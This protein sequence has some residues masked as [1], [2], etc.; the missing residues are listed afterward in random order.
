LRSELHVAV[1]EIVN[2]LAGR[3]RS[4][5][6]PSTEYDE[7][8]DIQ[9]GDVFGAWTYRWP[10]G[11]EEEFSSGRWYGV[12]LASGLCQLR[13]AWTTRRAWGRDRERAIV[14]QQVGGSAS[15]TYYP[16]AEF[17]ETDHAGEFAGPVPDPARPRALLSRRSDAPDRFRGAKLVRAD[18]AF[19][20]I[21]KGPSLRLIVGQD[22]EI[23]MV[24][25]AVWVGTIRGRL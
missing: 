15:Q 25:H 3:E 6:A 18:E 4:G 17:V 1:D 8:P 19:R 21:D 24:R 12:R 22:D 5:E 11:Q 20:T 14:F 7:G 23:E 10:D 13:L 9:P 16:L 2:R